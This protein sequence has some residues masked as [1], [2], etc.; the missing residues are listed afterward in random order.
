MA[1]ALVRS[2]FQAIIGAILLLTG[3]VPE[4]WIASFIESPPTWLTHPL[5]RITII[6]LGLIVIGISVFLYNKSTRLVV[7]PATVKKV[8]IHIPDPEKRKA[9]DEIYSA[10]EEAEYVYDTGC[11]LANSW[12]DSLRS[13]KLQEYLKDLANYRKQ[14][15]NAIVKVADLCGKKYERFTDIYDY[16]NAN[17]GFQNEVFEPLTIFIGKIEKLDYT[18]NE[19]II[20]LLNPYGENIKKSVS[21]FGEWARESKALFRKMRDES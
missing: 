17:F 5:T 18:I 21:K 16:R 10:L 9:I 2:I 13:G 1:G 19:G 6:F 14:V 4:Q 12:R 3:I 15:S 7:Q 11:V 8:K 20:D